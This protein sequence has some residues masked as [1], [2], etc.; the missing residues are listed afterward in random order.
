MSVTS[1]EK[2]MM[3]GVIVKVKRTHANVLAR[4]S[5]VKVVILSP[6]T[7]LS[8]KMSSK[9]TPMMTRRKNPI[10]VKKSFI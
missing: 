3:S 9:D 4:I 8:I 6:K 10:T 7:I 5:C 2:M 1:K